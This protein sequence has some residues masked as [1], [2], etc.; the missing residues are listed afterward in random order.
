MLDGFPQLETFG[1]TPEDFRVEKSVNNELLK[2]AK[3]FNE[4]TK[5][6][7]GALGLLKKDGPGYGNLATQ[8]MNKFDVYKNDVND[9]KTRLREVYCQNI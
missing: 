6:I 3:S 2:A 8:M 1:L 7:K 9:T 5:L 4:M